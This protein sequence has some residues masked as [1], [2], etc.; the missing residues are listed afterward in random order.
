MKTFVLVRIISVELQPQAM[1]AV[2]ILSLL[3][4]KLIVLALHHP[5]RSA[6]SRTIPVAFS[7]FAVDWN[8]NI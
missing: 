2:R 4:D 7:Y 3:S 8:Q 6:D 1:A 5:Q